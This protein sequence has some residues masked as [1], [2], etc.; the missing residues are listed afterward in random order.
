MYSSEIIRLEAKTATK[1]GM[2]IYLSSPSPFVVQHL[3]DLLPEWSAQTAWVILLLQQSQFP[4]NQ[5]NPVVEMEK[6]R[7]RNQF[8]NF[9]LSVVHALRNCS[10]WSDFFDPITGYPVLS[11]AGIITHDD[12]AV[13]K[14]LLDF[15]ITDDD[16]PG[17]IH[18]RWHTAVYPGVLMTTAT[19][20]VIAALLR[21]ILQQF[22]EIIAQR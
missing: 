4:L 7:L 3:K 21:P 10:F 12:V 13:A 22:D 20:T 11:R 2:E 17:L 9:S 14:A 5:F 1:L 18:P 8:M 19:P 15:S 16:C 6:H